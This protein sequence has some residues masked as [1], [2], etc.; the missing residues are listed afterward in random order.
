MEMWKT[1]QVYTQSHSYYDD[2]F[3]LFFKTQKGHFYLAEIGT[4]LF[5]VDN[6]YI[7][8]KNLKLLS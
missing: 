2:Y 3:E 4:F 7:F 1:F 6:I 8:Y 5:G